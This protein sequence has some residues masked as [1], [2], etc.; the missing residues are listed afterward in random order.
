MSRRET[1][2]TIWYWQQRGGVLAEEFL[3]VPKAPGVGRR[4]I[5]GLILL[6]EEKQRLPLGGR[7]LDIAGRDVIAIQTKNS[8]LG[9][10]LMGQT[11]FTAQLLE[12][13]SPRSI[14]SVA[15]CAKDDTRLRPM[16]EAH[17]GC[18]VVVCPPEVCQL[19]ARSTGRAKEL[20]ARERGR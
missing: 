16:L 12:A 20:R 5:D 19:T 1:D 3:V 10:Y 6:G 15:L 14:E 18:K 8:R 9:M 4:L 13:F 2:M 7:A 17:A 11:L